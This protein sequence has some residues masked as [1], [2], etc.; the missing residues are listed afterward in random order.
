MNDKINLRFA[1][2]IPTWKF[3]FLIVYDRA[4]ERKHFYDYLHIIAFPSF[5]MFLLSY[6]TI[7][8]WQSDFLS[9]IQQMRS[10]GIRE[11]RA[12][13]WP[14]HGK[15][16]LQKENDIEKKR[17]RKTKGKSFDGPNEKQKRATTLAASHFSNSLRFFPVLCMQ[18]LL[19][20]KK[21]DG[22]ESLPEWVLPA[23]PQKN[24]ERG[25]QM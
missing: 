12:D 17:V 7:D 18:H 3:E 14:G 1:W 11:K 21:T 2:V 10:L 13:K 25:S 23:E 9:I 8:S 16:V 6:L 15:I 22:E 20:R 24:I 5:S 4:A 19:H